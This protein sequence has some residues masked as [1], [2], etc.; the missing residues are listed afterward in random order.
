MPNII[1]VV[2]GKGGV[3][4]TTFS[5]NLAAALHEFGGNNILIDADTSNPALVLLL[6]IAHIPLTLQ[7]VLKGE[8]RIEHAIR[9]HHSGLR[10]VPTSHSMENR[11]DLSKLGEALSNVSETVIVDSPP[12]INDDIRSILAASNRV[13]VVTNPEIPAVTA[14]VKTIKLAKELGK[15]NIGLVVNRMRDDSYE[16]I[17]DEIEIMCETPILGIIPEDPAIRRASFETLP[18]IHHE[19]YSPAAIRFKHLA[20]RLLGEEYMPPKFLGLRRIWDKV[21]RK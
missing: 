17:R 12:G 15:N 18:V 11:L 9:V 1:S 21:K 3:G 6:H 5:I 13:I 10:V 19:P 2:S 4:K 7:D 16:L 20:A 8:A 14:A